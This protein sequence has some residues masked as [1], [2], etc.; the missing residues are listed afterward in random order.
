MTLHWRTGL[1]FL[2][3]LMVGSIS[4]LP[5]QARSQSPIYL[6]IVTKNAVPP[7]PPSAFDKIDDALNDGQIDAETALL[8]KTFAVFDDSRLPSAYRSANIGG[9]ASLFMLEVIET[10]S[11]LSA[12]TQA[13]VQP[14]FTPPYQPGSWASLQTSQQQTITAAIDWEYIPAAGGKAR[15]WY[16]RTNT[17]YKRK[18]GVI[19]TAITNDFWAKMTDL[20]G[21]PVYDQ[22]GV[23]NFVV[24]HKSRNGWDGAYVPIGA[25]G[26][27]VPLRCSQT[28]AIIYINPNYPDRSPAKGKTG[29]VEIAVHEFFHA[30]QFSY[31]MMNDKCSEYDW[32]AEATATWAEDFAYPDHDTEWE[33]AKAYLDSVSEPIYD[34]TDLRDYGL[35]LLPF[36]TTREHGSMLMRYAW[37]NAGWM[38]SLQAFRGLANLNPDQVEALF[39]QSP[40]SQYFFNKESMPYRVTPEDMKVI[41]ASGG[42]QEYSM[43]DELYPGAMRFYHFYVDPTVRTLVFY[44]GLNQKLSR[45]PE[46]DGSGDFIY[47]QTDISEEERLGAEV[48]YLAKSQGDSERWQLINPGNY[49]YCLDWN[50]QLI[51]EVLVILVNQDMTQR[52]RQLIS[53]GE[54]SKIIATSMPC[55]RVSGSAKVTHSFDGVT[56]TINA[57]NLVYE[58]YGFNPDWFPMSNLIGTND[59]AMGIKSGNV[60][61]KTEGTNSDGCTYSGSDSFTITEYNG[62]QLSLHHQYLP[63]SEQFLSYDGTGAPDDGSEGH[64]SVSCPDEPVQN[65]T[66]TGLIFFLQHG[67]YPIKADGSLQGQWVLDQGGG[68]ISVYEW[69]LKPVRQ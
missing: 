15:V 62:S 61:Y 63:G 22:A 38:D 50:K 28:P 39:N 31:P 54:D 25:A 60:T 21:E 34:R 42:Y 23:Q 53:V 43:K 58:M 41:K 5:T 3:L 57:T 26:V 18:A 37:M 36:F 17:D 45:V 24:F 20:M 2:F 16:P 33:Y 64:Y 49:S 69:D 29:L 46:Y 35:Y 47:E 13:L 65:F 30:L 44:D 40:F 9:Q 11:T 67:D 7:L 27:T 8:Y 4:V 59:I 68:V 56:T 1:V 52:D 14:F 51:S 12:Q 19:A 10:Y 48:I 6:P 32:M 66:D 55:I